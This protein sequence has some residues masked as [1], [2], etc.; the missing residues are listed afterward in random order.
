MVTAFPYFPEQITEEWL[1][2]VVANSPEMVGVDRLENIEVVPLSAGFGNTSETA[3][4]KAQ[5]A[6]Q[7]EMSR[8]FIVKSASRDEQWRELVRRVNMYAI[9]VASYQQIPH[10]VQTRMPRCYVAE[11]DAPSQL[12]LLLLEDFPDHRPG[13]AVAG[14]APEDARLAV[15][16]MTKLHIPFWN[17]AEST[18][19]IRG[20]RSKPG[21]VPSDLLTSGWKTMVDT[22]G[23][24]I[25]AGFLGFHDLYMASLP[26]LR[27]WGVR[28]QTTLNH[29]DFKVDNLLFGGTDAPASDRLVLVD[30]QTACVAKGMKDFAYL[31]THGMSVEDR[32]LFENELVQQYVADLDAADI[33]YSYDQALTDYRISMLREIEAVIWITGVSESSNER[34][35][36]RKHRLVDRAFTAILDHDSFDLLAT[37]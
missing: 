29:G 24:S 31:I 18:D 17:E 25:P 8:S 3:R 19:F 16:Q 36:Q 12:F 10:R 26:K 15:S 22:F 1:N 37:I 5:V 32:R 7:T 20:L 4:L 23:D 34:A 27:D 21:E 30:W 33:D 9:E 13:D 35:L 6:G 14:L 2:Q 11:M 28:G